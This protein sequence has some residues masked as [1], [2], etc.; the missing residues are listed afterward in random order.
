[1]LNK[2]PE[3]INNK[4][5]DVE[6]EIVGKFIILGN[7]NKLKDFCIPYFKNN[8]KEMSELLKKSLA[9]GQVSDEKDPKHYLTIFE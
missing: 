8:L 9:I 5:K 7:I 6:K 4:N 3:E 1:M 2:I